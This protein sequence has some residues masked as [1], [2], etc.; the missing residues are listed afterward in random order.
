MNAM[1]MTT[2]FPE[3]RVFFSTGRREAEGL[4]AIDD[5]GLVPAHLARL[6][7]L[8]RLRHDFPVV[9][10]RS[11]A[12]PGPVRSLSALVDEVLR[13]LAPR[14]PEGERL[15]RH[16]FALE[17]EIRARS[18]AG[19]TG[20]LSELWEEAAAV[21]GKPSKEHAEEVLK[22]TA[23]ALKADGEVVACDAAMPARFVTHAWEV[24]N[25]ARSEAFR[26]TVDALVVRLS[27]I[28]R[29]AFVHSE[30]GT[31]PEALRAS[32]AAPRG[33]EF[34]FDVM[35]KLVGRRVPRDELPAD[36]R[37]R[38]EWALEAL[39]AQR[40]HS[41]PMAPPVEGAPFEFRFT[42]CA[43]AA[44]AFRA[45][46]PDVV[47][48]VKAIAIAELE[49]DNRY[50]PGRHDAFF[51]EFG[52]NSLSDQD[53]ALFPDY[54]VCMRPG[55]GGEPRN[56]NLMEMLSSGLP[57]KVLVETD[58][59]FEEAPI[60]VGR[61]AFGVKSTRLAMTATALGGV[62]VL[63][64]PASNLHA[65][66]ERLSA[67]LAHRGPALFSVYVG[68]R[69]PAAKLAP[70]LTSA[71]AMP[72]R[73]FPTFTYDPHA[74]ENLAARFSFENNPDPEAD[75]PEEDVEYA[76]EALQR[77]TETQAFTFADFALCDRRYGAHFARVP[78]ERWSAAQCSLAKW[79]ELPGKEAEAFVPYVLAVD[80]EDRLHRLIVDARLV[81][82]V[83]RCTL[84]W[85]RLQEQGGIH[86]SH[87]ER[88][89]AR[90]RKAWEEARKKEAASAP[91]P[92]PAAAAV[93]PPPVG[94]G[95]GEGSS[96]A[97]PAPA[98]ERSPDEPWI[99]T[100]RCPSCNECQ[101]INDKLFL[102]NDNKQA[103]IG[104]LKAGTFRQMVEAAESCQV[105]IIHP[106]KPWNPQEP[107]LE[108]LVERARPFQ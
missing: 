63:Q 98:P 90:E 79:L 18:L 108:E 17:R 13:E 15:R 84:L 91:A 100:S 6:R 47:E 81:Q 94:E 12:G 105:S 32:L 92:A 68:A 10:A 54:L 1:D 95:R 78:R 53:L 70:Y 67:G 36:R 34:D 16:A 61:F 31:R 44:S 93:P 42:D 73:A 25:A 85:H 80:G 103:C 41:D 59:A 20:M 5:L 37:G 66:G 107:G 24:A 82:A 29:A 72:A 86:N 88:L 89:L 75:W 56:A 22:Y 38:I 69:E 101:L 97:A 62:F 58:D 65:L 104:D 50:D 99:E 4:E 45:R 51:A 2:T 74:G 49:A 83:R 77:V 40:F 26:R 64:A 33:E 102:Y 30:A 7:D 28:L 19:E 55:E 46:L 23:A 60:G 106:G 57:V 52:E 96:A 8:P 14:G 35:A 3:Q 76:D 27:D 87:A 39:R 9:L 48:T 21:V 71:A 43:S 11:D